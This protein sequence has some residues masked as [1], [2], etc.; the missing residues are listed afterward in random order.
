[1]ATALK[2]RVNE[3]GD[4]VLE[5]PEAL[6]RVLRNFPNRS[7]EAE[8]RPDG[9][10]VL[11]LGPEFFAAMASALGIDDT[12]EEEDPATVLRLAD[13]ARRELYNERYHG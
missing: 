11:T 12:E 10:M 9:L 13:E 3:S 5:P 7:L 1:M 2:L 4:L 6:R 8:I